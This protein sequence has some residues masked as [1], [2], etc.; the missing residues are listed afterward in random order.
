MKAT[1]GAGP[2]ALTARACAVRG[3]YRAQSALLQERVRVL[4]R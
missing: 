1:P 4:A 2:G 3:A